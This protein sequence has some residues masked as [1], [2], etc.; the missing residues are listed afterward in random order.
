MFVNITEG[1]EVSSEKLSNSGRQT[2][3]FPKF[4]FS[5]NGPKPVCLW[6]L[7]RVTLA[8]QEEDKRLGLRLGRTRAPW[9]TGEVRRA[10][11]AFQRTQ[12]ANAYSRARRDENF[13][14]LSK[15]FKGDAGTCCLA[16]DAGQ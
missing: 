10:D 14:C 11:L 3:I 1:G 5:H 13:D 15:T 16:V 12:R 6:L 8:S 9:A 2:Q 7:L 4:E